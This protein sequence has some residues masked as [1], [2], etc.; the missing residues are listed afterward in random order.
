MLYDAGLWAKSGLTTTEDF[1]AA[2]AGDLGFF[3]QPEYRRHS[4]GS[5]A[6]SAAL[7]HGFAIGLGQVNWTCDADNPGSV[8]TAEKLDLERIE[9]Y[10]QAV[11]IMDE[12]RH[13]AFF[14]H[15]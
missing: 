13:M 14:Q 6:A 3:A 10:H 9:D 8:C 2:G 1:I 12:Q 11:L 4:L 5:I 7:E 15:D